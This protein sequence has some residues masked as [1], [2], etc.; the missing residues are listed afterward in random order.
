VAFVCLA[1]LVMW[2][3]ER[4]DGAEHLEHWLIA[5]LAV[6]M[7]GLV[8]SATHLGTPGNA[9]YVFAGWGRSPLSNEVMSAL[10]FLVLAGLYWLASFSRK[11]PP[12]AVCRVWL[13]LACVTALWL[14][15]MI[16][17]VYAIPTIPPWNS[18][19]VPYGLWCM[20]LSSG[21]LLAIATCACARAFYRA[22][23]RKRGALVPNAGV[24]Q[25]GKG[26]KREEV[27]PHAEALPGE[28]VLVNEGNKAPLSPPF[29][30]FLR[31]LLVVSSLAFA[32][33]LIVFGLQNTELPYF[34]NSFG[35]ADGLVPWY[36][37]GIV[38]YGVLGAFGIVITAAP[39][40][41][42][43][44][45]RLGPTLAGAVL[46]LAGVALMRVGFYHLLM[47]VGL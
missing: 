44:T 10:G 27:L 38:C 4:S 11:K 2:K 20:A 8:A 18:E 15:S 39:L 34:S 31:I 32:A 33:S 36:G 23:T 13:F 12:V 28:E 5:P 46:M 29:L 47:T 6:C 41:R 30:V 45:L 24:V 25:S 22:K 35:T 37:W 40:L 42:K 43:K 14:V 9:L 7:V 3:G 21:P 19:L 1:V 17:I 26:L 16:S